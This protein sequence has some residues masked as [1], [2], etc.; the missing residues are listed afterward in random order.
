MV[1][2]GGALEEVVVDVEDVYRIGLVTH[3]TAEEE[4][5]TDHFLSNWLTGWSVVRCFCDHDLQVGF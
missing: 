2:F 4:E 1:H 5:Q 3:G